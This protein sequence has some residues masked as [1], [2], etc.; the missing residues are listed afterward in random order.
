MNT[1]LLDLPDELI[2]HICYVGKLEFPEYVALVCTCKRLS[3]LRDDTPHGLMKHVNNSKDAVR[4]RRIP[5]ADTN[6]IPPMWLENIHV[7]VDDISLDTISPHVKEISMHDILRY[8]PPQIRTIS[9][10]RNVVIEGSRCIEMINGTEV[11]AANCPNLHHVSC[12][13]G[14]VVGCNNITQ[15]AIYQHENSIIPE[16]GDRI[17][18]D[19]NDP[20]IYSATRQDHKICLLDVEC[21][22]GNLIFRGDASNINHLTCNHTSYKTLQTMGLG[23]LDYYRIQ[24]DWL[25]D[26]IVNVRTLEYDLFRIERVFVYNVENLVVNIS[27]L[28]D[29]TYYPIACTTINTL[30]IQGEYH[31]R[32]RAIADYSQTYV[33]V[34]TLP[35]VRS[36]ILNNCCIMLHSQPTLT[37]LVL[38]QFKLDNRMEVSSVFENLTSMVA[39]NTN[40]ETIVRIVA[41]KLETI[42]IIW[43]NDQYTID[44]AMNVIM[45][46]SN[47]FPALKHIKVGPPYSIFVDL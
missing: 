14:I 31:F 15:L 27:D 45:D 44:E 2:R 35:N 39:T 9:Y 37:S 28:E 13:S 20:F 17:I 33:H 10:S 41:P 8:I 3:I 34:E 30:K 40:Y 12:S 21:D 42:D 11:K 23:S 38:D 4:T 47:C 6:L 29:G 26:D 36:M 1:N 32:G 16:E 24:S 19:T 18:V 43:T 25:Y 7:F 22:T 5:Y 46:I